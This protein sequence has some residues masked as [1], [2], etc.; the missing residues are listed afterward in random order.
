MADSP[1]G[2]SPS[3]SHRD[4]ELLEDARRQ[5]D[6]MRRRAADATLP[7]PG[8]VHTIAFERILPADA[9]PGYELVRELRRGAQGV[10][11]L[12][13]QKSTHRKVAVKV[14]RSGPFAGAAEHARFQ[15]EV[16]ILGQLRHPHIV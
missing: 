14:L 10:V 7:S 16:Q 15:R 4:R 11:Y 8:G 12:A 2:Q 9:L 5:V 3:S 1:T 13:L 6:A